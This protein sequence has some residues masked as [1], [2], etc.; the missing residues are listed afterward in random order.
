[1]LKPPASRRGGGA[2]LRAGPARQRGSRNGSCARAKAT[3]KKKTSV[4]KKPVQCIKGY[5]VTGGHLKQGHVA[6]T[7]EFRGEHFIKA[8]VSE[9]WLCKAASG[10][11]RSLAPLARTRIIGDLRGLMDEA[12]AN[13]GIEREDHAPAEPRVE[14]K[15]SPAKLPA[16]RYKMADLGLDAPDPS[17]DHGMVGF[18]LDDGMADLGLDGPSSEG[19]TCSTFAPAGSRSRLGVSRLLMGQKARKAEARKAAARK[20]N[21]PCVLKVEL[22]GRLQRHEVSSVQMLTHPPK[23]SG[24]V[25]RKGVYIAVEYVPWLVNTMMSEVEGG[26][27]DFTPEKCSLPTPH[28]SFR[29]SAW[30][31]RAKAPSGAVERRY[32]TISAVVDL[33]DGRRRPATPSELQCRKDAAFAE[34][35]KWQ[36]SFVDGI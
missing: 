35:E 16:P 22:P 29:D 10:K 27:V 31:A 20:T 9:N 8:C 2:T 7:V 15:A 24:A 36:A 25:L 3:K 14:A 19:S 32:F 12:K 33:Q 5:V 30:V 17:S 1:M 6:P 4:L 23:G 21:A 26:G 28:F 11:C 18:G 13:A 34:A